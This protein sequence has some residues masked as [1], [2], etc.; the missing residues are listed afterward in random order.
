MTKQTGCQV[1]LI[2]PFHQHGDILLQVEN[3]PLTITVEAIPILLLLHP[4]NIP[5]P[6]VGS[7]LTCA[8]FLLTCEFVVTK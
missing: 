4:E 3:S 2:S 6:I 5:F 1:F 8:T 7:L